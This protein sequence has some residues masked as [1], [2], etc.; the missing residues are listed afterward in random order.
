MAHHQMFDDDD[1]FL[2]RIRAHA[3]ALPEAKEKVSHGRPAFHTVKVFAYFGGALKVNGEWE[4]HPHA[5]II[6]PD[7]EEVTALLG[8]ERCWVPAYLGTSGWLG[9]DI[10][11]DTHWDEIGELLEMSYR[12]TATSKLVARLTGP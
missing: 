6:K 5:I 10:D 9:V 7:T 11:A 2:E 1:P 8:E 3:L 12:E 4:Q